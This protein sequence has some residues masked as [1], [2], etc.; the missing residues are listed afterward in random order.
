ME[1]EFSL[2]DGFLIKISISFQKHWL[3]KFGEVAVF[4]VYVSLK[5]QCIDMKL[6]AMLLSFGVTFF[7]KPSVYNSQYLSFWCY[8]AT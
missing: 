2:W 3:F 8:L 5:F 6:F 7:F 1:M 4:D